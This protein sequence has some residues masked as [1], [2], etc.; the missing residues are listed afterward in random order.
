MSGT[1]A[2]AGQLQC[3]VIAQSLH[4]RALTCQ[5]KPSYT[6]RVTSGGG[7]HAQASLR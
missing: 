5:N 2:Q 6:L 4:C 1:P 7:R 3:C